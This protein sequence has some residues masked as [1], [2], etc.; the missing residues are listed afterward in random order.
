V[1]KTLKSGS[2]AGFEFSEY[3]PDVL[4]LKI[5]GV[6]HSAVNTKDS[7]SLFFD[8]IRE[9][10]SQINTAFYPG[11][12]LNCLFLGGGAYSLSRAIEA[13]RASSTQKVVEISRE[14]IDFVD[15]TL[16]LKENSRI[17]VV[18]A[19]AK[20]VIFDETIGSLFNFIFVDVFSGPDYPEWL[21][22]K[23]YIAQL[24][25]LLAPG[26]L[27]SMNITDGLD[28]KNTTTQIN[29][30]LE[31]SGQRLVICAFSPTTNLKNR[32]VILSYRKER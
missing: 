20:T 22:D 19:D 29:N 6:M 24:Y 17:E 4:V 23:G 16:P 8:Y 9:V 14:I 10:N 32:N 2:I 7:S 15:N 30:A 3:N 27:I 31:V 26:G 12:G 13:E 21:L 28:M 1:S 25:S 5:D 11:Q 18:C